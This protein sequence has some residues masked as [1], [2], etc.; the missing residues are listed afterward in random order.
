[1]PRWVL[2][3]N[4]RR[5][6]FLSN[7]GGSWESYL[8]AF[9]DKAS[10]GLTGIWSNTVLCPKTRC[11]LWGGATDEERFKALARAQQMPTDVWYTA[12]K[13]LTV[14]NIINN[15][16]IRRGLSGNMTNEQTLEWLSR[17]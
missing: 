3:E 10:R 8:G 1:M 12:Y 7:Y 9:V 11:L 2:A 6:L 16:E 5:L 4:N 17:L 14:K 15:K 13:N